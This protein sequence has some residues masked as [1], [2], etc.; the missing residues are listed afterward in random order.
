[1]KKNKIIRF[2]LVGVLLAILCFSLFAL[3]KPN[4]QQSS[5]Q[6]LRNEDIK[7]ISSQK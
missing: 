6:K 5:S 3:L 4:S 7:K 1:M 2:S